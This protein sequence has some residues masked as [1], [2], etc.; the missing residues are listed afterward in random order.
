MDKA[1]RH[2]LTQERNQQGYLLNQRRFGVFDAAVAMFRV[3]LKAI[4]NV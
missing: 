4:A 1:L 3:L 2:G